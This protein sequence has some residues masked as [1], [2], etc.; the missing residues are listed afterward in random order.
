MTAYYLFHRDCNTEAKSCSSVSSCL[1]VKYQTPRIE[2]GCRPGNVIK[3]VAV[4]IWIERECQ[5]ILALG[6]DRRRTK[7]K[8][9]LLHPC[10]IWNQTSKWVDILLAVSYNCFSRKCTVKSH[11]SSL[12]LP[13]AQL[14][15][16]LPPFKRPEACDSR[17]SSLFVLAMNDLDSVKVSL[18][19]ATPSA[20][21]LITLH[22][23]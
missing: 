4:I 11:G 10:L 1:S 15:V 17:S 8:T 22:M 18:R 20:I 16:H 21:W 2:A 3:P 13:E 9:G 6:P 7:Q 12:A 14:F 23:R 19:H 5:T